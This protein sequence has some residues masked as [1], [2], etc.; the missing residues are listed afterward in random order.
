[1]VGA[2]VIRTHDQ[3]RGRRWADL[4]GEETPNRSAVPDVVVARGA[5]LPGARASAAPPS[6]GIHDIINS[7]AQE[8]R[9]T[10][11]INARGSELERVGLIIG[12]CSRYVVN[13]ER[14]DHY[15]L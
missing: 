15:L 8:R 13:D 7:F 2:R 14:L 11:G 9:T 6:V 5:G 4:E 3:L 1:M 10:R 12:G